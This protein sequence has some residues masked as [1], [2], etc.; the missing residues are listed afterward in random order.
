MTS[1]LVLLP[2]LGCISVLS[3]RT[4][5]GLIAGVVTIL[6]LV[7]CLLLAK[8]VIAEGGWEMRPGGWIG[9]ELELIFW[10]DGISAILLVTT[11]L[12]AAV[13]V[14]YARSYP[15][16]RE[17]GDAGEGASLAG[18]WPLLLLLLAGINGVYLSANLLSILFFMEMIGAAA[19][20]SAALSGKRRT[21]AAATRYFFTRLPGSV[22]LFLGTVLLFSLY[23]SL[24]LNRL[25]SLLE[26]TLP[27]AAACGLIMVGVLVKGAIFPLHFWL[28]PAH[29]GA[30]SPVS[31]ILSGLV[32]KVPLY[33][34]LRFWFDLF[35]GVVSISAAQWLG[36]LGAAGVVWGAVQALRQQRLKLLIAH[37]TVS[38]MGYLFLLFPLISLA[39]DPEVVRWA[40][41]GG[42]FQAASHALAK[43][44]MLLAAGTILHAVGT[45][46]LEDLCGIA[47]RLPMTTFTLAL[48]SVTLIG[49]PPSGGFIA[50]WLLL[51]TAIVTGQWWWVLVLALGALLT[52]GYCFLMLSYAF[53]PPR[54]DVPPLKPVPQLMEIAPLAL[55]LA[56]VLIGLRVEEVM[57]LATPS[58][59]VP[60][61]EIEEVVP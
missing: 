42:L 3:L 54:P 23:G 1:W 30:I 44:A 35:P 58:E 20:L 32:V 22:S 48:A 51:K 19:V 52:S 12:V 15:G 41:S 61:V 34:A 9:R 24:H 45:D 25:G 28:P 33:L 8:R 53:R 4:R 49:L 39:V 60:V 40:W 38:Q 18:F 31:A 57:T 50:K 6:N 16:V 59:P 56:A 21:V 47:G 13:V 14:F 27:V 10:V 36:L 55:A 7:L 11:A 37:S 2:L 5:G 26:P 29:A 43:A 17:G 46:R